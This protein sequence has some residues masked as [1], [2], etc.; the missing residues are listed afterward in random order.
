MQRFTAVPMAKSE[1]LRAPPAAI[2]QGANRDA[3]RGALD[4]DKALLWRTLVRLC[5]ERYKTQWD[6]SINGD[7]LSCPVLPCPVLPCPAL[8]CLALPY[9]YR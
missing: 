8:P 1:L 2:H 5:I 7:A 6:T 4:G 3:N 9:V